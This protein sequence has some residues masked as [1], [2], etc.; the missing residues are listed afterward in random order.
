MTVNGR[1][2]RPRKNKLIESPL[3]KELD[4]LVI[5]VMGVTRTTIR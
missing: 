2:I 3:A 1:E 4:E 5:S